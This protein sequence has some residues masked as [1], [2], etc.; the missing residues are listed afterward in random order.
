M[1]V[2]FFGQPDTVLK[3]REYQQLIESARRQ[4]GSDAVVVRDDVSRD[5]ISQMEVYQIMKTPAVLI[6]REDGSPVAM[7]QQ[8]LPTLTEISYHYQSDS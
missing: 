4:L 6:A 5:S 7:W 3:N 1:Q 8:T 2:V